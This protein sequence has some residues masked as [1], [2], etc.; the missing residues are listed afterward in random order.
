VLVRSASTA[1]DGDVVED[2]I[3]TIATIVGRYTETP[4]T[5]WFAIWEGYGWTT[6]TNLYWSSGGG[7]LAALTRSW[8]RRR[9]RMADRR[10]NRT[11]RR[12]LEQLPTFDLPNRRYYLLGGPLDVAASIHEPR[13]RRRQAPDLW[14]PEDR[15]WFVA[16]DT[17]LDWTY[18]AGCHELAADLV[19]KFGDRAEVVQ[20]DARNDQFT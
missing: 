18:V 2:R 4:D 19:E 7:R 11:V 14:W 9:I 8:R 20:R 1:D 17:D 6:T 10:R 15:Q 16:T 12:S 5:A 3:S 13:S